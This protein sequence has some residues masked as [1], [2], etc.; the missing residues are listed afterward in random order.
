MKINLLITGGLGYIGSFTA[1][2][3]FTRNNKKAYVIDDLSRGN[4]FAKKYSNYKILNV[5]EKKTQKFIQ[6]KKINTILHLAA[7][8]CVRESINNKKKYHKNF[9]SQLKFI[10]LLKKTNVK[11]LIFSSSLSVFEGN[12][13]KKNLSPYSSYKLK[14]ERFLK[15]ISSKNFKVIVLRYPNI[16]G[17]EPSGKL[18]EKNKFISRIVPFFYKNI[19][20][21]K[22]N[23][24]FYDF[25]KKVYPQR[26]YMHVNDVSNININVINNY[27]KFKKNFY[28]F[29]LS[30]RKQYSNFQVLEEL[31]KIMEI[32]PEYEIKQI[33]KK[34]SITQIYKSGDDISKF[35]NYKPKYSNLKEILKTNL[36]WF[37]K[38]Y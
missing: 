22:K 30:N 12:K 29:N 11:Y 37:K 25:K 26:S 36:R 4:N 14:L 15:K 23:L 17:S 3:I 10:D 7:L 20:K 35:I 5:S 38:I 18:G 2:N 13:L 6:D 19:L 9:K 33:N 1:R 34:E 16:I 24:L 28:I 21:N 32:K 8:T 27:K 31:S